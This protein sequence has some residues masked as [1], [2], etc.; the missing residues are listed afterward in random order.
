[1]VDRRVSMSFLG[2]YIVAPRA[3]GRDTDLPDFGTV[4]ASLCQI[5]A[6]SVPAKRKYFT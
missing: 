6:F 5:Q 1:M 3:V 4:G 2:L